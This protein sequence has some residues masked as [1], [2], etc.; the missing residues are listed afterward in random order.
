MRPSDSALVTFPVYG[1]THSTSI[2]KSIKETSIWTSEAETGVQLLK[3]AELVGVGVRASVD[4]V[5]GA[6]VIG[7][8]GNGNRS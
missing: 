7:V 8:P 4:G 2:S 6:I 1:T 3:V 5:C